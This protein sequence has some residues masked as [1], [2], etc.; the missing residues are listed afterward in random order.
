MGGRVNRR[1][2]FRLRYPLG[3]GPL[4]V[5][6]EKQ[7]QIVELSEGGLQFTFEDSALV[8]GESVTGKL[9][10]AGGIELPVTGKLVR[11]D[12]GRVAVELTTKVGQDRI[13]SEQKRIIRAFPDFLDS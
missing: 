1:K 3:A 8:V 7:F 6:G 10:F 4:L 9:R 5:I 2:H 11:V 12:E 13:I